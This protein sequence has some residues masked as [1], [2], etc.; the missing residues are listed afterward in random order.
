MTQDIILLILF[1]I[2]SAICLSYVLD[3]MYK[4][5]PREEDIYE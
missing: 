4:D 5:I 2:S 3:K 1:F